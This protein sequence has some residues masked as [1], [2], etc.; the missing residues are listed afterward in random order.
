VTEPRRIRFV[1]H[2]LDKFAILREHGVDIDRALVEA[3]VHQPTKTEPGYRGRF[4]AQGPLDEER[5]LRVVYE[6]AG[7]EIVIVTFYP[8]KRARYE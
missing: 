1:G 8:G 6:E 7:G 5:V 3:T 4:I 2:A